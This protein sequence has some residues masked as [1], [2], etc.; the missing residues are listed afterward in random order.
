[1]IIYNFPGTAGSVAVL[2]LPV[3]GDSD[4]GV[5]SPEPEPV[6]VLPALVAEVVVVP[7]SAAGRTVGA[8]GASQLA[9]VGGQ[10]GVAGVVSDDPVEV[11]VS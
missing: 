5:L 1:M 7:G 10:A 2:G 3:A 11:V 9:C 8:T 4:A 6:F